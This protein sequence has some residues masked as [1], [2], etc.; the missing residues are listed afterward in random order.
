MSEMINLQTIRRVVSRL[1]LVSL[2]EEGFVAYSEGRVVVPPVGEM[3]FENPPGETHIKYGYIKDGEY[4]VIKIAS[5][6]YNNP[7]LGLPSSQGLMLLFSQKTGVLE[8]VLLDEGYLTNE[9]TAAAGAV[10][11]KHLAPS[12]VKRIGILGSGIQGKLQLEHLMGVVSCRQVLVWV[13]DP[14]ETEPY[15]N[16]FAESGL[17]IEIA[18][19]AEQVAESC[20]LI[21]TTTPSKVPLLKADNIRPGTHITAMG[22]DTSEKIELEPA[23]LGKAH[24]VV[25]DSLFQ[26]E[27]RGEVFRAVAANVLERGAVS[28]LGS[29]I[30]GRVGGRTDDNQIT[31]CDLTGVAVQ[32][33]MI[34]Q[35]VWRQ[36]EGDF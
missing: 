12:K 36:V 29:V 34:A 30:S 21:V 32:D 35:A 33:L 27:T 2:M 3:L 18:E 22:S 28:E 14:S 8:A 25:V 16:Y 13:P 11:A 4:Y 31:V 10:A 6:F 5:G 9:R 7:Q 26:S 20:N 15:L 24:L 19:S 23:V 1:D 17:Q